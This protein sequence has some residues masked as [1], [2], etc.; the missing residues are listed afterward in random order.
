M[1][2]FGFVPGNQCY[3]FTLQ[4]LLS[5]PATSQTDVWLAQDQATQT[6]VALKILD[7]RFGAVPQRLFEAQFGARLRHVNLCEVVGADVFTWP[8]SPNGAPIQVEYVAIGFRYQPKGTCSSLMVG[9]GVLPVDTVHRLLLDVLSGLQY[10]HE[11]GWQ[12]NDIKPANILIGAHD[13]FMLTDYGIAWAPNMGIVNTSCY[14]PHIAPESVQG[15]PGAY[16]PN[17]QPTAQTDLYQ[18][19]VMAYRLLNGVSLIRQT[20][21]QMNAAGQRHK[22]YEMVVNGQIPDRSAYHPTVPKRL[23]QIV[24]RALSLNPADRYSSALEMRRDLERL[25]YPHVWRFDAT[26]DLFLTKDGVEH[27]IERSQ[28]GAKHTVRLV[29]QFPS[30]HKKRP[31]EFSKTDM[32]RARADA[33]AKLII[34]EMLKP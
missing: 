24:N 28:S 5:N 26:G 29:K 2:V 6:N 9:P 17:H 25:H 3:K 31:S 4:T 8:T 20:F 27:R 15:H 14:A 33:H 10:L 11:Q 1:S 30:G 16:A 21:D 7:N 23:R 34:Q 32:T 22:F 18:L 13:E 19:G 12:H